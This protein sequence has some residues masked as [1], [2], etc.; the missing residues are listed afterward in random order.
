LTIRANTPKPSPKNYRDLNLELETIIAELQREDLDID[1][2]LQA[3]E[4]GLTITKELEAYLQTAEN[5][6]TKLQAKFVN[7]A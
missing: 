2:A 3:Y 6:V 7:D 4:R 1:E 5:K